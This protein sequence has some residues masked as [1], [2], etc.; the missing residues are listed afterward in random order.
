VFDQDASVREIIIF[1]RFE[2][3]YMLKLIQTIIQKI[4]WISLI[5]S[6]LISILGCENDQQ[7]TDVYTTDDLMGDWQGSRTF[8][9][10]IEQSIAA[11]VVS[12][13]DSG[14]VVNIL[15]KFDTRENPI[16][17]LSGQIANGEI[18]V[19]GAS[20]KKNE[21]NGSIRGKVFTGVFKGQ[22]S[23]S[24]TLSK[25]ERLSPSLGKQ[26]PENG[27][28]LFGGLGLDKWQHVP[29]P[30]GFIN[31]NKIF[32]SQNAVAYMESEIFSTESQNVILLLGSDDAVKVWLND[33]L[34]HANNAARGAIADQDTAE[35]SLEKGWNTFLFKVINGAGG[36]GAFSRI[37]DLQYGPLEN[38]SEKDYDSDQTKTSKYLEQ[39]KFFMT[40]WKLAG[41]FTQKDAEAKELFNIAFEPEKPSFAGWKNYNHPKEDI[42][43]S[44]SIVDGAMQ[45]KPGSNSIMTRKMFTD[46]D[47]HIEFRSP[48]TPNLK[49][50][51]RGNSGV[52]LQGRY[53]VQVLDSYGLEGKDNECGGIY[54]VAVPNVNMC[55]PPTQWQTYDIEFTAAKYN[56]RNEKLANPRMTARHNGIIIHND[57]EI[58]V[59]TDGG[60]DK[61]MS[62]PG[63]IFLQD[64]SDLVQYRNIW[65]VEK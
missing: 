3:F 11:Q 48:F 52:Y 1:K 41:P 19:S 18:N 57:L 32:N 10:G 59:A 44:W 25:I 20:S 26:K 64:H 54:K 30:V 7:I 9:D 39:N 21:W 53:E 58:P 60:L 61:D 34:V 22:Q 43:A 5:S 46:F 16:V 56:E 50:Q 51:S 65:I 15:N 28:T 55:A 31:V 17:V 45:V 62:K 33:K 8:D 37:V 24:F 63:P 29:A 27:I 13:G 36:W 49:G 38:I 14:Y 6:L 42:A 23:G 12:Y 35:I 4:I 2:R 47:L 40:Q